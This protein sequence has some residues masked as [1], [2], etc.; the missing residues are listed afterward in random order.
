MSHLAGDVDVEGS[1][2]EDN[3]EEDSP[4]KQVGEP[5]GSQQ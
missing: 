1:G 4:D 5:I 2:E 3:Q